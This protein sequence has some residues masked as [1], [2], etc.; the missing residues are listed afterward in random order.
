LP[1]STKRPA[2]P[3]THYI[4]WDEP[5]KYVSKALCGVWLQRKK[6]ANDP[7]CPDCVRILADR[8][9]SAGPA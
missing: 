7:T 8:E 2:D 1:S 5:G 4:R 3:P 6:H 9:A